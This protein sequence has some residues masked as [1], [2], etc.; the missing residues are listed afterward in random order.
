MTVAI[1]GA[2]GFIGAR[3]AA[4]LAALDGPPQLR[5]LAR[6]QTRD[7]SHTVV[8]L[9]DKLSIG[10]ALKACH[11]V[12]HC[13]FDFHDMAANR[14]IALGLSQACAALGA[15]LIHVST[16]A[17]HEPFPDGD[18]DETSASPKGG[19]EYKHVK[20]A[21]EDDLLGQV[22]DLG[23]DLVIL[24]PTVVYGPFGRAWTD[25]PVRELLTGKVVLPD[26]GRGLCNAVYVDDVC[27]AVIGALT[28]SSAS[29]ERILVS[30]PRPVTWKDFYSAYQEILRTDALLLT[31]SDDGSFVAAETHAKP[32]MTGVARSRAS[33]VKNLVTRMFGAQRVTRLNM[34]VNFS[35]SLVL[36]GVV[37]MP[38]GAKLALFRSRCHIRI[39]K[40]TRLLGYE[41][42]YDLEDGMRM[43]A[44]YILRTYGRFARI[45]AKRDGAV[46]GRRN[47]DALVG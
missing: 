26:E 40:A 10:T 41:P 22:R 16:A 39:D 30:G 29:G 28:A 38:A 34:W 19:S 1:T 15:R 47:R 11:A 33:Q 43:T 32:A 3:V 4:M 2:N 21:I 25:S 35:R 9:M 14:Q 42:R 20:L 46:S 7:G 37:H 45:R 17:V 36:G 23:L 24:Q 6:R 18:L 12:I 27:R 8:D 5:L 44:P 13:A 31:P